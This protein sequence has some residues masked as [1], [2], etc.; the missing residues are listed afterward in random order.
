[1][2][3]WFNEGV[4]DGFNLMLFLLFYSFEDFVKYII[5]EL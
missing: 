2:E 3:Y 4:V 1:M 5:L